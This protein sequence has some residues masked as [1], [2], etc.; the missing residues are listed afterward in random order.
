MDSRPLLCARR[1]GLSG[2]SEK[3]SDIDNE[4]EVTDSEDRKQRDR[5]RR[6]CFPLQICW[7]KD[8]E[9]SFERKAKGDAS[10]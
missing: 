10:C 2:L 5:V 3:T 7:I 8:S 1:N 9:S 6:E 4:T